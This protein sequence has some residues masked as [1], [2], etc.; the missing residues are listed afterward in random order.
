M[1]NIWETDKLLL[2]LA[3]FIP[4]FISLKIYNLLVSRSESDFTKLMFE[5]IGY[6]S[7]NYAALS[8]LIILIQSNSFYSNHQVWYLF[9]VFI[10]IFIAPIIWPIIVFKLLSGQWLRKYL[11]HPIL[12]PWDYVFGKKESYWIIVHLK[13]GRKIGGKYDTKSFASS[14]PA[15]EQIY[16]EEVWELNKRGAF[17]KRVQETKGILILNSEII[18]VEYF[19]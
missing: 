18:A 16:L 8:P 5:V 15:D 14:F 12:K 6:S 9:I 3:F 19:S 7:L 4:G 2:F 13:D 1:D 10:I 11:V 17:I